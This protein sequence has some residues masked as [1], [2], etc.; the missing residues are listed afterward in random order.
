LPDIQE[1]DSTWTGWTAKIIIASFD[2]V[3]L[4]IS[5]KKTKAVIHTNK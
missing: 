2:I 5:L 4:K 1:T 3:S